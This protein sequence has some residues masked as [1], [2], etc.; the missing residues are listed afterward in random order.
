MLPCPRAWS[1]VT[2]GAS[3]GSSSDGSLEAWRLREVPRL[4]R[5][6]GWAMSR[7]GHVFDETGEA[8]VA[9]FNALYRD[10]GHGD[11]WHGASR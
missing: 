9:A 6:A 2:A 4:Q 8:K 11:G 10:V 1:S 5:A 7:N 3:P